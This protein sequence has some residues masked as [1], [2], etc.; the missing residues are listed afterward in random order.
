MKYNRQLDTNG[1]LN[2]T[3]LI[4]FLYAGY[5]YNNTWNRRLLVEFWRNIF[6]KLTYIEKFTEKF[7]RQARN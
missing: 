1:V 6:M 4:C 7:I 5:K 3:Y 2:I